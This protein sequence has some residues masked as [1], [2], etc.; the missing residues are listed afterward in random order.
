MEE[1]IGT[2]YGIHALAFDAEHH[3]CG[4]IEGEGRE[5]HSR[6]IKGEQ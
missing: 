3:S 4:M 5:A 2:A 1:L 6:M